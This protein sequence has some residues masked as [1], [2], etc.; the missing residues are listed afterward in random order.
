MNAQKFTQ[1]SI[2]AIQDAQSIAVEYSNMNI[3]QSHLLWAL[4]RQE[5]GL[6]AQLFQRMGADVSGMENALK[7]AV[8]KLPKVTGSGRQPDTVYLTHEV[9]RVL[10]DAEKKA[11]Q[12]KDDYVSVEHIL[13]SLIDMPDSSVKDIFR[14]YGIEK[15]KFMTALQS[16]RGNAKVTSQN[17]EETYDV[18]KK[19]GQDLVELARNNKLDP[20]IGRDSEIRNVIRI[21]SRKTKNNP[22]L[23]GEPGVGKTAIAEGLALRIVRG[24]VPD[25]LKDRIYYEFG[26]NKLEQAAYAYRQKITGRK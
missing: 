12:M 18:L 9:D 16:V 3:E 1:K 14:M 4:I 21:L 25:S 26:S 6:A 5:N 2:E 8:E 15:S 17:P 22:V 19:Y 23:I 20:V 13:L 24:D 7:K 10:T 11:E